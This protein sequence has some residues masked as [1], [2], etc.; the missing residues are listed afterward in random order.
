MKSA[1][2]YNGD[3]QQFLHSR[4]AANPFYERWTV[5]ITTG[6]SGTTAGATAIVVYM[7]K[8]TVYKTIGSQWG[9][10]C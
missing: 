5:I 3:A 10:G 6:D 1:V 9:G 4:I 7:L 8:N 2:K